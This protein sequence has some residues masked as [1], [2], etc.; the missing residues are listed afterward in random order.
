MIHVLTFFSWRYL[1]GTTTKSPISALVK[2]CFWAILLGTFCLTLVAAIMYGLKRATYITL[3]NIQPDLIM[4]AGNGKNLDIDAIT[5]VIQKEFPD[6]IALAPRAS[7]FIIL[8]KDHQDFTQQN[9]VTFQAIDPQKEAKTTYIEQVLQKPE[10]S[11]LS[12]LIVKQNIIIGSKLAQ[13]FDINI[14]DTLTIYYASDQKTT[15]CTIT[16]QRYQVSVAGIFSTGIA[17][18]DTNIIW[19]SFD[20]FNSLFPDEGITSIGLRF[21]PKIKNH[22]QLL[23]N[24]QSRFNVSINTWYD[25][26]PSLL[27]ALQLEQ[28]AIF[29][30]LFF[31]VFLASLTMASTLML[32]I[33]HKRIDIALLQAMGMTRSMVER[34]FITMGLIIAIT[35]TICGM[36]SGWAASWF[37]NTY[38]LITLPDAYYISYLPAFISPSYLLLLFGIAC[39]ISIMVVLYAV[40]KSK[41]LSISTILR[42]QI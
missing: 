27:Q 32:H 24:L 14:G 30:I 12:N 26:Y 18:Y 37:I 2:I 33:E 17:D 4:Q 9:I 19:G 8:E 36:L 1:R 41:H 15:S 40:N 5:H 38:K 13:D 39:V 11:S 31:I 21:A 35:A 6:V 25:L 34:I 42:T 28:Y 29:I 3:Q 23:H 10:K 7:N 20:L 16:F 22:G